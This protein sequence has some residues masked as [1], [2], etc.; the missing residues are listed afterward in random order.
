MKSLEELKHTPNLC[1]QGKLDIKGIPEDAEVYHGWIDIGKFKGTVV[2]GYNE[3]GKWEHVSISHFNKRKLPT[4]ED[5][6]RVKDMFWGKDVT[7]VQWHPAED[8]YI[9]GVMGQDTNILHLWRAKDGD[10]SIVNEDL[11]KHL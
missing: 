7:V 11:L 1:V 10:W 2:F 3:H 5:M 9:H 4:W 8:S 6:C